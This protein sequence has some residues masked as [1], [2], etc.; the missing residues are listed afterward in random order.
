MVKRAVAMGDDQKHVAAGAHH[1]LPLRERTKRIG[2]VLH[3]MRGQERVVGLV[4]HSVELAS[5]PDELPPRA[6]MPVYAP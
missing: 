5:L 1:A 3:H 4:R 2:K 6:D